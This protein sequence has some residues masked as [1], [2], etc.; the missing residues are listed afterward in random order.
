MIFC[1]PWMPTRRNPKRKEM[2]KKPFTAQTNRKR[3]HFSFALR[4]NWILISISIRD[5]SLRF[6]PPD[7]H[8]L[9]RDPLQIEQRWWKM[10]NFFHFMIQLKIWINLMVL[11][12]SVVRCSIFIFTVSSPT[13]SSA[14]SSTSD[15]S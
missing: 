4:W 9:W 7:K 10:N 13:S 14:A 5:A 6:P 2:N 1:A 11:Y 8:H 15:I 3:L 12:H